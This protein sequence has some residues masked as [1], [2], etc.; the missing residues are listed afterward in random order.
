MR[1]LEVFL[2]LM[3]TIV[4][5][6]SSW[7]VFTLIFYAPRLSTNMNHVSVTV[8]SSF[9]PIFYH[10]TFLGYPLILILVNF[11]VERKV[12]KYE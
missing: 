1:H 5:A 6:A 11:H 10:F 3:N 8:F 4:L 9:K 12:P 2:Q 7:Y